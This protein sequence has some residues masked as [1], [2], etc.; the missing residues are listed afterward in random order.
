MTDSSPPASTSEIPEI[1]IGTVTDV[2]YVQMQLECDD[3]AYDR[4]IECGKANIT[5]S[6]YFQIGFK[7]ILEEYMDKDDKEE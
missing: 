1:K 5:D 7:K 2:E 3:A 6:D 4:I